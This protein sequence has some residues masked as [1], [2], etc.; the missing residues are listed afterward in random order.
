MMDWYN[1]V[2]LKGQPAHQ[3]VTNGPTW[4]DVR[5]AALAHVKALQVQEAS[6]ERIIVC[7][8]KHML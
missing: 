4:V 5:D 2:C 7:S 6:G 3:L 1:N 8:S